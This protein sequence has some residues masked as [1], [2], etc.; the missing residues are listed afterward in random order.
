M[1]RYICVM[2]YYYDNTRITC[3]QQQDK[4]L[5]KL[6]GKRIK[7]LRLEKNKSLNQFA[8]NECLITSATLSRVE[9]GMVDLKFT[10]LI[11]IANALEI[12]PAEL[13]EDFDFKYTDLF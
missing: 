5:L 13:L 11:K 6:I 9:N 3:I 4:K 7:K 1:C 10:T 12:T 2:E 8:F